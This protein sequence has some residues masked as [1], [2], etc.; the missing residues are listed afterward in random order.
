MLTE[1][2]IHN[3]VDIEETRPLAE[4]SRNGVN[5]INNL[6][7]CYSSISE[8][9]RKSP[10]RKALKLW[11]KARENLQELHLQ[12]IESQHEA[13]ADLGSSVE[14]LMTI[15]LRFCVVAIVI[16]LF[17]GVISYSF[18]F[19]SWDVIDSLYFSVVTF[20]TVGYGDMC[21]ST[22]VAKLFTALYSLT[23]ISI[24][25]VA[26]GVIGSKVVAYETKLIYQADKDM[27]TNFIS[28][29][30]SEGEEEEEEQVSTVC[31]LS[32][33]QI[34]LKTYAPVFCVLLMG[35]F[36]IA[37]TEGWGW[38]TAIYYCTLTAVTVGY[39]DN[40]PST[41]LMRLFAV[42]YIPILV[43]VMS[44][45]LGSVAT[46]IMDRRR[47]G[48]MRHMRN[49]E[50]HLKDLLVMDSDGDGIVT[51]AE[52]IV[53]MLSKMQRVEK[54]LLDELRKQFRR[55][56]VNNTG[57]LGKSDLYHMFQNRLKKSDTRVAL[58]QY[59]SSLLQISK[60]KLL[61][62]EACKHDQ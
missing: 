27:E 23:G 10:T 37:W 40:V 46:L 62:R 58:A 24:L 57:T 55:F 15:K 20:T 25:G 3:N 36:F 53:F 42:L 60:Q 35:S 13:D 29:L 2:Q 16:Y 26:L 9:T 7:P 12:N 5:N 44:H 6:P 61:E 4:P 45:F 51:E 33:A 21:P 59:K 38:M 19:E 1:Q 17:I 31:R 30:G 50:L 56:D 39:G 43:G 8:P 11:T 54:D 14:E 18:V 28:L 32:S 49:R 41:K 47:E 52:F 22:E 48:L 34:L